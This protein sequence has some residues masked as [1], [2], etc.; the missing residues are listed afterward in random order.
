MMFCSKIKQWFCNIFLQ[1]IQYWHLF[2]FTCF[3]ALSYFVSLLLISVPYFLRKAL[4]ML[5]TVSSSR[6]L[7]SNPYG[8]PPYAAHQRTGQVIT[9]PDLGAQVPQFQRMFLY[10]PNISGFLRRYKELPI[11]VTSGKMLQHLIEERPF[12][13]LPLPDGSDRMKTHMLSP[14]DTRKYWKLE[15][16]LKDLSD[17]FPRHPLYETSGKKYEETLAQSKTDIQ[18]L[19]AQVEADPTATTLNRM[20]QAQFP[21]TPRSRITGT[22]T[23]REQPVCPELPDLLSRYSGL[24]DFIIRTELPRGQEEAHAQMIAR[25]GRYLDAAVNKL[26]LQ[27]LILPQTH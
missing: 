3:Y 5:N 6:A 7:S 23:R 2:R 25:H 26:N 4:L 21:K 27:P 12:Q 16:V 10:R 17:F 15:T 19:I 11:A 13:V 20:I 8:S 14:L 22:L 1:Y 18:D 9:V 24:G